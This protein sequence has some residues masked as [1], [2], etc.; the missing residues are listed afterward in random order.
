MTNHTRYRARITAILT[1][2]YPA[3][4]LSSPLMSDAELALRYDDGQSVTEAAEGIAYGIPMSDAM[5]VIDDDIARAMLGE[6]Y[7]LLREAA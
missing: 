7:G 1:A 3:L 6:S 2:H 5:T 4:I